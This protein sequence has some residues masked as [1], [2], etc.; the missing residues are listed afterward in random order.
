MQRWQCPIQS[1]ILETYWL[2]LIRG[3]IVNWDLPSLEG[4]G[5]G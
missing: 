4:G 2:H 3:S 1:G 5:R